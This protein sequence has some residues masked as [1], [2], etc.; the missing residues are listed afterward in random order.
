MK[1]FER[2][3]QTDRDLEK[4]LDELLERATEMVRYSLDQGLAGADSGVAG[5]NRADDDESLT[6]LAS[7]EQILGASLKKMPSDL[8]AKI[9]SKART[10]L[11]AVGKER[12]QRYGRVISSLGLDG[13]HSV[14]DKAADISSHQQIKGLKDR[15]RGG[16][17]KLLD[18][19]DAEDSHSDEELKTSEKS[20][21]K[22][23]KSPKTTAEGGVAKR[24]RAKFSERLLRPSVADFLDLTPQVEFRPIELELFLTNV[25][26]IADFKHEAGY[27]E[28][29]L[30]VVAQDIYSLPPDEK[31]FGP[32]KI[33]E[34]KA[35][36]QKESKKIKLPQSLACIPVADGD[37]RNRVYTASVYLAETDWGGF[38]R[39]KL[40]DLHGMSSHEMRDILFVA[41]TTSIFSLLGISGGAKSGFDGLGLTRAIGVGISPAVYSLVYGA[42]LGGFAGLGT[43][44][45]GLLGMKLIALSTKLVA[46]IIGDAVRD[47]FFPPQVISFHLDLPDGAVDTQG[48]G[49]P[50]IDFGTSFP[51]EPVRFEYVQ[52]GK[53]IDEHRAI[54]EL[55]F[56]WKVKAEL[57]KKEPETPPPV[58]DEPNSQEALDNL[59]KIDHIGVIMLENRSFDQML[60]FLA[61][62]R[63]ESRLLNGK[64]TGMFNVLKART[65]FQFDQIKGGKFDTADPAVYD[66]LKAF[67]T[68]DQIF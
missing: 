1:L 28:I 42:V 64:T 47:E 59:Q 29:S 21:R 38:N 39:R 32:L 58:E 37:W 62:D 60:S 20:A 44:L 48:A 30:G 24:S 33:G 13:R 36:T 66:E 23:E 2:L 31:P 54:Y 68:Q 26:C 18:K 19:L 56:E 55:T 63:E 14:F 3:R 53:H 25:E 12:E 41:Y 61:N 9:A 15:V 51:I 7:F 16:V 6:G 65:D 49:Q 45:L 43:V 34:F 22:A 4:S 52:K 5:G 67:F 50:A 46:E 11:S 8:R 10:R 17:Q 40:E 57:A 35:G 27:D